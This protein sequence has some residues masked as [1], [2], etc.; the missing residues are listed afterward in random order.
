VATAGL[1]ERPPPYG[2]GVSWLGAL[3]RVLGVLGEV[4]PYGLLVGTAMA[5]GLLVAAF[6]AARVL[7]QAVAGQPGLVTGRVLR[8]RA[9]RVGVPRDRDP[10][11]AGRPRP[12]APAAVRAAA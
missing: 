7:R 10:D 3:W 9:E 8:Q 1:R 11:A 2:D 4:G 12:R 6:V 5:A